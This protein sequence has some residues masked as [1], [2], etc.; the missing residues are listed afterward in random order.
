MMVELVLMKPWGAPEGVRARMGPPYDPP[1]AWGGSWT[2]NGGS[3]E[4]AASRS[5][6]TCSSSMSWLLSC[7]LHRS[8]SR[9]TVSAGLEFACSRRV[10]GAVA[11]AWFEALAAARTYRGVRAGGVWPRRPRPAVPCGARAA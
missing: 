2:Q 11:A 3:P 1:G 4:A 6:V 8:S 10:Y 9:V 5:S 7:S